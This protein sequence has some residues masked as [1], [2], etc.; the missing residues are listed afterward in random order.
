MFYRRKV[1]GTIITT[2][3]EIYTKLNETAD[4]LIAMS[5][6]H[7]AKITDIIAKDILPNIK[8]ILNKVLGIYMTIMKDIYDLA[9][10][11]IVKLTDILKAHQDDLKHIA[12]V[13]SEAFQGMYCN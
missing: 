9:M 8:E 4:Q 6:E 1:F 11:Y 2:L 7:F 12:T 5:S 13:L 10:I 3:S